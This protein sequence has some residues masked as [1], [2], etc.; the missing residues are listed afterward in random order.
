MGLSWH[1]IFFLERKCC[2][3]II[4][5]ARCT[6]M[7]WYGTGYSCHLVD[8]QCF[9][10][11]T[12]YQA[13]IPNMINDLSQQ[14]YG[15][16]FKGSFDPFV[17][18][19]HGTFVTAAKFMSHEK[20][21]DDNMTCHMTTI[22]QAKNEKQHD[23][24]HDINLT[25]NT[26]EATCQ[27]HDMQHDNNVTTKRQEWQVET[28]PQIVNGSKTRWAV[29]SAWLTLHAWPVFVYLLESR[30]LVRCH[31]L[32]LPLLSYMGMTVG[33]VMDDWWQ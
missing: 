7:A 32:D 12:A 3:G 25:C 4:T 13:L 19:V 30:S 2:H 27:Q 21:H 16:A 11:G 5:C 18:P 22:W 31:L 15:T 26:W 29:S 24:S 1:V 9:G 8:G 23:M 20:Q 17:G 28:L 33:F 14:N 10:I 6:F